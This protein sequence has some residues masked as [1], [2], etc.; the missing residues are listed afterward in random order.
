MRLYSLL[1]AAKI[2]LLLEIVGSR[3][4][5]FH[6][7]V[8]VM[9]SV[10]LYDRITVR[11]IG[12]DEIRL[13]CNSPG[14]PQDADNLAHQAAVLLASR[15]PEAMTRHGGVEITL[16]KQI[17]VGAGLAGGSSNAAAVLVGLDLLWDLGLTQQEL[18]VIGAE[19]GSDVPFAIMGGCALATGR[20]ELLDP[21]LGVNSLWVLLAKYHDLSVSTPWAY[22]TYRAQFEDTYLD[23]A[24][25]EARRHLVKS[26]SL[27]AAL[28]QQDSVSMAAALQNDL[29]KVVLPAFPQ[30]AKL[31]QVMAE[32]GGLG[33]MMS[34]SGPTVFTLA[35][36]QTEAEALKT[37][38]ASQ[39]SDPNLGLW[40][41]PCISSGI[42][43]QR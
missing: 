13:N 18:Q 11:S 37:T 36:S 7:L 35:S 20:G 14:V 39:L 22:Q 12:R 8:M 40:V 1:A 3:L 16:E 41:A 17:P 2:N 6:E 43:L 5:G 29:E 19:L 24:D 38:V 21:I 30:V 33:T 25:F 28:G 26:G 10:G 9:Q 42:R 34:G 32:A 4:D 15:F 31:R 23:A 27:V